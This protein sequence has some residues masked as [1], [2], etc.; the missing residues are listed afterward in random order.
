MRTLTLAVV[1]WL[2]LSFSGCSCHS[3][4]ANEVG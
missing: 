4:G 2:A 1:A 3:T